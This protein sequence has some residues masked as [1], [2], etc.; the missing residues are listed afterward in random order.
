MTARI[1]RFPGTATV[2]FVMPARDGGWLVQAYGHGW[3]CG[4]LR[5]AFAEARW[6][7]RNLGLPIREV[8]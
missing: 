4:D 8:R 5:S 6:L 1:I 2:I 3:I 7:A